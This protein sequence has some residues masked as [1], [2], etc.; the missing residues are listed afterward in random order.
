MEEILAKERVKDG[1]AATV[2]SALGVVK[3][4]PGVRQEGRRR[5]KKLRRRECTCSCNTE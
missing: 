5:N 1:G 3:D 4:R 2:G